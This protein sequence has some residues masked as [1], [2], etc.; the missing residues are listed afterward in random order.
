MANNSI[1]LVDLDFQSIKNSLKNYLRDNELFRDYDFEDSNMAMLIDLMAINGYRTAFYQ[2]MILNESFLDSA[3]LRNSVLSR[4]KE[5][6]YLPKSAKSSRA[7]VSATF[8]ASGENAPYNIPKGSLFSTQIKNDTYTFTT[9]SA[10]VVASANSTYEFETTLYEGYYVTDTYTYSAGSTG[11]SFQ[12][13]NRDV[14][15]DS[16]SV[17]VYEDGNTVG[18]VYVRADT[19]LDLTNKSKV[20]FI[21]PSGVGYF[22]IL[23]GDN[24]IGKRPKGD[25]TIQLNYRV[26]N[27]YDG[28]G[29]RVFALDF[30][31]TASDELTS[32]VTVNTL[33]NSI[34]GIDEESLDSIKYNAPRHFQVQER[35]VTATDYASILKAQ[36]PE[37]RAIY[38]YGGEELTPAIYG[39]VYVSVDISDVD[40][41]PDSKA[42]EYKNFLKNRTTFGIVPFFTEPSFTYVKVDSKVRYNINITNNSRDTIETLVKD[43]V[44]QYR[45]DN[46]DEFN[47]IFRASRLEGVIDDADPSIISSI[48][49]LQIYKKVNPTI[50]SLQNI[51]LNF[52]TKLRTDLLSEKEDKHRADIISAVQSSNFYYKSELCTMDDDGSGNIRIMKI[53]GGNH[54]RVTDI[55]TVDYDNGIIAIRDIKVDSYV[56]NSI[57]FFCRPNDPDLAGQLNNI[58]SIEENE[59]DITLEEIRQ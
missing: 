53:N 58:V 5:L 13:T 47:V 45:D 3:V 46:L 2:N 21:E 32:S 10:L 26:T 8:T 20:F 6:N 18:A 9:D 17:T 22:N 50:G 4:S 38:A 7:R 29:A 27:G 36:F 25:A 52:G 41:L 42:E 56:G 35:A 39:R 15:I 40:G 34:D 57:R 24:N 54:E 48:T 30:D 28:N 19:L 31:P 59:I 37:I 16:L 11:Q 14:D 12:V 44:V 33:Q 51:D 23:F 55:G 49:D 1:N 43:A